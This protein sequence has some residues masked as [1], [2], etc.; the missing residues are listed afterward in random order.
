MA[1]R[2]NTT[3]IEILES[4]AAN[5]TARLDVQDILLKGVSDLVKKAN[6]LCESHTTK[7]SVFE[8][9]LVV[10][11]LKATLAAIAN[12]E[13][14]IIA[15][16]KDVEAFTTWKHEQKKDRDEASRRRWAFGPNIVAALISAVVSAAIFLTGYYLNKP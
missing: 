6:E 2:D 8:Q 7:I 11:D 10:L 4:H 14:E 12:V 9:Q 16:K 15:I 5:V 1:G 3:R 13:K